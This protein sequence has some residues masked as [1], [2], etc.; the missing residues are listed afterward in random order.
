MQENVQAEV[1]TFYFS[2][3]RLLLL[4]AE[5][6][7]VNMSVGI[8]RLTAAFQKR[9]EPLTCSKWFKTS[10]QFTSWKPVCIYRESMKHYRRKLL[11]LIC[12][13]S[14]RCFHVLVSRLRKCS[15]FHRRRFSVE[16]CAFC[17]KMTTCN[18]HLGVK[19]RLVSCCAVC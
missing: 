19:L 15:C 17:F 6:R 9:P 4:N 11:K 16:N 14:M 12:L 7:R 5:E 10:F 18:V 8:K 2:V 1:N 13:Y 3:L